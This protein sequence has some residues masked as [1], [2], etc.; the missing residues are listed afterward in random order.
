MNAPNEDFREKLLAAEK[1][2]PAYREKYER[3]LRALLD[4]KVTGFGKWAAIWWLALGIGFAVLFGALAVMAPSE[5]HWIAR[6]SFAL[7]SVFG[8][9]W[10][11]LWGTILRRGGLNLR[12]HPNVMAGLGWGLGISSTTLFMLG[13]WQLPDRTAGLLMVVNGLVFLLVAAVGMIHNRIERAEL[14]TREKLL[15]MECRLAEIAEKLPR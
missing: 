5:L 7:G 9:A 1:T 12:T 13:A 3:E 6:A 4:Q 14:R 8:A 2:S 15:E 11:V 10:A